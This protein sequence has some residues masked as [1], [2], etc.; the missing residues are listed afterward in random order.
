M[1][2]MAGVS[3]KV[4]ILLLLVAV[5]YAA[6]KAMPRL[7]KGVTCPSSYMPGNYLTADPQNPC[8]YCQCVWGSPV[9]MKC[10]RGLGW[11]QMYSQ[12]VPKP[13]C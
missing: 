7:C 5:V 13:G 3:T 8:S 10:A 4:A 2:K 11:N 1:Q 6:P 12:C 9:K